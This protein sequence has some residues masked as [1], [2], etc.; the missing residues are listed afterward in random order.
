L[1]PFRSQ[2]SPR[3]SARVLSAAASEPASGSVRQNEPISAPLASPGRNRAFCASVPSITIPWL[4]IPRLVPNTE[5][6]AGEVWPSAV[7]TVTSSAT[8]SPSPP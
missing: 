2:P 4:P 5:R 6:K 1:V 3:R 8:P 7:A